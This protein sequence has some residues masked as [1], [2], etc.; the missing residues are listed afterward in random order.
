[1]LSLDIR[2]KQY[3]CAMCGERLTVDYDGGL[4]ATP[5]SDVIFQ[6]HVESQEGKADSTLIYHDGAVC[7][8]CYEHKLT[9]ADMSFCHD[10]MDQINALQISNNV[11]DEQFMGEVFDELLEDLHG[12]DLPFF[13][14]M[15][16][17][18]YKKLVNNG[19]QGSARE[20]AEDFWGKLDKEKTL[21]NWITRKPH[22]A[23]NFMVWKTGCNALSVTTDKLVMAMQDKP[24]AIPSY[25]HGS[26]SFDH[27]GISVRHPVR[28]GD[29]RI[30]YTIVDA[31]GYARQQL[32]QEANVRMLTR[33]MAEFGEV[34]IIHLSGL[35]TT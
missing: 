12:S 4:K 33:A 31:Q 29:N 24:V 16:S 17:A 20:R 3:C 22:H 14:S 10:V 9:E 6:A 34:F 28:E 15:D 13:R 21:V 27:E 1:M 18:L 35:L 7:D 11:L 25:L 30:F 8:H 32:A 23:A 5:M 2:G 19:H 26:D